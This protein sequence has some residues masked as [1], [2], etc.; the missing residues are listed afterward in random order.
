MLI[1]A[2]LALIPRLIFGFLIMQVLWKSIDSKHLLIK[3]FLAGPVGIGLS[4]LLSFAW[5]WANLDLHIYVSIETGTIAT[6][7][8]LILWWQRKKIMMLL[9]G[10]RSRISKH[11]TL[12]GG[13]L[14]ISLFIFTGEFWIKS[15]QNPHGRW[16]AW[17][18]WNVVTR[19]VFRGG[20]HWIGT[21]LR[22]YDHPDYPFL[23]TMSNATTWEI[24]SRETTRGPMT[25]G[26]L[27][28][29]CLIGLL[30][31]L[32]Y[33]L[34]GFPQA[35]LVAIVLSSQSILAYHGIAQYAD[36]PESFYFLAS[37]GLI[38]IYMSGKEKSI[39]IL[40]GFLAGLSAWTKN[41]GL[42]FVFISLLA[43]GFLMNG[44]KEFTFRPFILGLA[45]P[46]LIVVLFKIFL[47]PDN[48][49]LAGQRDTLTL[50]FDMERYKYILVNMG[51]AFWVVGGGSISIIGLLAVYS[52]MIGKTHQSINGLKQM[53]FVIL[54]QLF[55]YFFI[56]VM[57]PHDLEWHFKTSI[58]RL[59]L[60]L[61]PLMLLCL[62][63]WLKTPNELFEEK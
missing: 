57:T 23:L 28:T 54:A 11:N 36:M 48:D 56:Y 22:I 21:F 27:F 38:P 2:I 16:D 53:F 37:I 50:L 5:L 31:S 39:P 43:W 51:N 9:R 17:S 47:A 8:V 12:W 25:L 58:S 18:N 19:F 4:S 45:L 41:E 26:F 6:L 42:T 62:F 20:E 46:A 40:A 15:L 33:A 61:F 49:L 1:L 7:S 29:V 52:I 3:F 35:A 55:V 44:K 14:A 63:L 59:Y 32:I 34:R 10:I 30:F 24:L 60:H 13:L